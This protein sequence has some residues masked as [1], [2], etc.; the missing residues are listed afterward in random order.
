MAPIR[1]LP[2]LVAKPWHCATGAPAAYLKAQAFGNLH[3][4]VPRAPGRQ[5]VGIADAVQKR[6][7]SPRASRGRGGR[8]R[9]VEV[10]L[11]RESMSEAA[12]YES[13]FATRGRDKRWAGQGPRRNGCYC[14]TTGAG[15]VP[16][17]STK[18]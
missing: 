1:P 18:S 13:G 16:A 12:Q 4:V 5:V 6:L 10:E 11:A 2:A 17:L 15:T 14:Y 8:E 3:I 9:E 7:D